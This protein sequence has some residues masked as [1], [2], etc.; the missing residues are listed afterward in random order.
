MLLNGSRWRGRGKIGG[1][2][3]VICKRD[4]MEKHHQLTRCVSFL[5]FHGVV[6]TDF[7]TAYPH[8]WLGVT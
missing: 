2:Q 4:I 1:Q 8:L 6:E 7:Y 3:F 5:S